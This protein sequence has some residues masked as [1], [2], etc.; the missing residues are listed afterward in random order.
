MQLQFFHRQIDGGVKVA[1]HF[2]GSKI[3]VPLG[4][5]HH[6]GDVPVF[7]HGQ[8]HLG[9]K[10]DLEMPGNAFQ[11]FPGMSAKAGVSSMWRA[12]IWICIGRPRISIVK[13]QFIISIERCQ[14]RNFSP[15][16]SRR[17]SGE[18]NKS[19]APP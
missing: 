6:L 14:R 2:A 10:D 17:A 5:D 18:F 4:V 9:A 3:V 12:V 7:L 16:Y 13:G 1:G 15:K 8:N 11:F 19:W